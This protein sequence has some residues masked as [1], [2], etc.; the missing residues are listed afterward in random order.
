MSET[1]TQ[2]Q[3]HRGTPVFGVPDAVATARYYVERLGFKQN[4]GW[5]SP[6]HYISVSRDGLEVHLREG[7][8]ARSVAERPAEA[9]WA[10]DLYVF[11]RDVHVLCEEL[12]NMGVTIVREPEKQ[13]Y[14]YCDFTIRDMNGYL[15]SF[16]Q[17]MMQH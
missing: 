17:D 8:D 6:L 3:I 4:W 10:I 14:G 2:H 7:A 9:Y 16:G 11:V 15:I 1:H 5:G 12:R 13:A